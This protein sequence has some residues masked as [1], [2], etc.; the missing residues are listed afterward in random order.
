ME[1]R[2]NTSNPPDHGSFLMVFKDC[3]D[4]HATRG[5]YIRRGGAC[6]SLRAIG[7]SLEGAIVVIV[8]P[9]VSAKLTETGRSRGTQGV[10]VFL[11]SVSTIYFNTRQ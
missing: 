9:T 2:G 5:N 8:D 4:L 1:A 10:A 3:L 11:L 6:L 7:F